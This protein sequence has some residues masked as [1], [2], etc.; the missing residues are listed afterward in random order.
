MTSLPEPICRLLLARPSMTCLA[1]R[2]WRE[3]NLPLWRNRWFHRCGLRDIFHPLASATRFS[4][5]CRDLCSSVDEICDIKFTLKSHNKSLTANFM[6]FVTASALCGPWIVCR[7]VPDSASQTCETP[8]RS[9]DTI[10]RE[11]IMTTRQEMAELWALNVVWR[12]PNWR[13]QTIT[14]LSSDPLATSSPFGAK[15]MHVIMPVWPSKVFDN[16]GVFNSQIW[17]PRWMA[18]AAMV[19]S[20]EILKQQIGWLFEFKLR[21]FVDTNCLRLRRFSFFLG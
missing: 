2:W 6:L 5:C 7:I 16:S 8:S 20:R 15:W 18:I 9:D 1:I 19:E 21:R 4:N 14:D 17:M 12:I 11:S 13:P 3:A 10:R